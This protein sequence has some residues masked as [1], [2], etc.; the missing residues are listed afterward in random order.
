MKE[1]AGG[2]SASTPKLQLRSPLQLEPPENAPYSRIFDLN[3]LLDDP[4]LRNDLTLATY[5]IYLDSGERIQTGTLNGETLE[6]FTKNSERIRCEIGS[7]HWEVE[8][9]GYDESDIDALNEEA[10]E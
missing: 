4:L 10:P 3:S 8:E 6:V 2:G 9:D 1:W 5:S 7:G